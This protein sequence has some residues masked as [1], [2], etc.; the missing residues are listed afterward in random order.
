M[1]ITVKFI[2][3]HFKY[4]YY[5]FIIKYFLIAN[6]SIWEVEKKMVIQGSKLL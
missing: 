3:N 1:Y 5:F 6:K 4:A 2:L